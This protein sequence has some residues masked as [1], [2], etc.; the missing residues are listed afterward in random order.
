MTTLPWPVTAASYDHQTRDISIYISDDVLWMQE[1]MSCDHCNLRPCSG[2][3]STSENDSLWRDLQCA[4]QMHGRL[5]EPFSFLI[6]ISSEKLMDL[7]LK[8]KYLISKVDMFL[9]TSPL[10]LPKDF[11]LDIA[12]QNRQVEALHIT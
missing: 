7:D 6:Y 9:Q 5:P 3:S 1:L 11:Y 10:P 2:L 12:N 8:L 4:L